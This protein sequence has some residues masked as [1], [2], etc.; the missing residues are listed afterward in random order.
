MI[1][2]GDAA[3]FLADFGSSVLSSVNI[4]HAWP[5]IKWKIVREGRKL[6]KNLVG[7]VS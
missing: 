6:M 4:K 7:L 2:E 5:L 1:S 3:D